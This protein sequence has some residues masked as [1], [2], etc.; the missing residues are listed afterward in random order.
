MKTRLTPNPS[1]NFLNTLLQNARLTFWYVL[2]Q[3]TLADHSHS[4][5]CRTAAVC[6]VR[7]SASIFLIVAQ[8]TMM[9]TLALGALHISFFLFQCSTTSAWLN[10][11]CYYLLTLGQQENLT[12]QLAHSVN[13]LFRYYWRG[14]LENTLAHP[15]L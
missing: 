7:R 14:S 13:K 1:A 12:S 3:C 6:L 15:S 9:M 8:K 10:Y 4:T 11:H 2:Q 5:T